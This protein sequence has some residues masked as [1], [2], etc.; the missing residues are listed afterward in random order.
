[1]GEGREAAREE[2]LT[3]KRKYGPGKKTGLSERSLALATS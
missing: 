2:N 1:M 3:G